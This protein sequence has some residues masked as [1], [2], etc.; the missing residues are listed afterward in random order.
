MDYRKLIEKEAAKEIAAIE[1]MEAKLG[2][3][4]VKLQTE[5]YRLL[6]DKYIDALTTDNNGNILFNSKNISRVNDLNKTWAVFQEQYYQPV[7][8]EFA[9]D[10]V[11]IVD[12][13]AGYFLALGKEFDIAFEFAKITDLI[14]KQIGIDLATETI[15][16]G[17]YLYR[18]LEGSQVKDQVA[19][20]VLQNVSAKASF[21]EM[22]KGLET[23]I[24]G[25]ETVNGEMVRYLRTYA[26]DSFS[27]VQRSIDLNIADTYGLNSFVYSGDI[28]KDTRA[29][30]GGGDGFENKVGQVFTRDDLAEWESQDWAGKN[31]DVPVEISLGGY[32]CRHTLM[33]IPDEA[34]DYFKE[35]GEV[36]TETTKDLELEQEST[37]TTLKG[38][39]EYFSG[40]G[41]KSI[42]N[43]VAGYQFVK[44]AS[45][46][47][48]QY[49]N[50]EYKSYRT[51]DGFIKAV[52]YRTKRG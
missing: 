19:N 32:N 49:S 29:F 25:D 40:E 50:G 22:R 3:E 16:E 17:S 36:I 8:I 42:S 15:T 45:G 6:V 28:I 20:Y 47:M 41:T 35:G 2:K 24:K 13:E 12:V 52:L 33:W 1:A 4:A 11:S 5:L 43:D 30:C 26:Y 14:S 7:L 10:L 51:M 31:P 44:R 23:M 39:K 38:L 48:F 46:E 21:K 34:V 18:L 27:N 9:K 37:L